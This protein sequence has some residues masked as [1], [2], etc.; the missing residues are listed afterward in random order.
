VAGYHQHVSVRK[1][2]RNGP[3]VHL[4]LPALVDPDDLRVLDSRVDREPIG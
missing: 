4:F 1:T 3:N 2:A